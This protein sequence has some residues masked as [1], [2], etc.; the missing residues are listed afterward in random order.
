MVKS[1]SEKVEPEVKP[2][3]NNLKL[4]AL[5]DYLQLESDASFWDS[6]HPEG[7]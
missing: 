1:L 2:K 5:Q 7:D 6:D 4:P 3:N